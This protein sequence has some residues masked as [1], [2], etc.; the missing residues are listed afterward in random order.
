[1]RTPIHLP[2]AQ[3][4]ENEGIGSALALA[5]A[6][7][8]LGL[9]GCARTAAPRA[10]PSF[11]Y[12]SDAEKVFF[13]TSSGLS[14]INFAGEEEVE[15]PASKAPNA[16]VLSADGKSIAV[17]L[18]GWGMERIVASPD[19]RSYRI[20]DSPDSAAFAGLATG[21]IWPL[22]GGFLIHLYRDPF[23]DSVEGSGSPGGA[24]AGTAAASTPRLVFLGADGAAAARPDPF[25]KDRVAG[26][27]PFVLLPAEGGWFA[28]LR[29]D[30]AERVDMKYFAIDDPL[31]SAPSVREIRRS[32]FEDALEPLPLSGLGGGL[33]ASLR[34][35]L[36]LLGEGPW[37][38]RLRS[39]AGDDRWYLSSGRPE[40]ATNAFAWSVAGKAGGAAMVLVLTPDGRLALCDGRDTRP[41]TALPAPAEGAT[42]TALAAAGNIAAAAWESG[43]FPDISSAGIA[44]FP[45]P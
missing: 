8:A 6:V 22:D 9:A 18:N 40:E 19:G 44:L 32:E 2:R 45:I 37:L 38:A 25:P 42:F 29:K 17:A 20:V 7:L 43:D 24:A 5:A 16:S 26:F 10:A 39:G 21:G 13:A 36:G 41:L 33:G 30:A 28:Q 31:A 12:K 27:E 1:M 11:P 3:R 15:L 4:G 14:E 35:A 34:S 23:A